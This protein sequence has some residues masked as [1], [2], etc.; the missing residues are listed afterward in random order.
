MNKIEKVISEIKKYG[1]KQ[2]EFVSPKLINIITK[3]LNTYLTYNEQ[4]RIQKNYKLKLSIL[5]FS[6][7][8]S[9]GQRIGRL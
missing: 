1:I 3:T 5:D 4:V 8:P 6:Q 9:F 7:Y 2:G